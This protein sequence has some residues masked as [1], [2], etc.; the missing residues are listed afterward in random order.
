[1]CTNTLN[2]SLHLQYDWYFGSSTKI[3]QGHLSAGH[4]GSRLILRYHTLT[5]QTV[6]TSSFNVALK[7]HIFLA[8]D[9][10]ELPYTGI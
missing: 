7:W 1:M 2:Y 3:L 5:R 9:G 8:N 4:G 10:E 6:I